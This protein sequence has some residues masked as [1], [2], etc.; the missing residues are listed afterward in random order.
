MFELAEG[1][2]PILSLPY[3]RL[4]HKELFSRALER[5]LRPLGLF[6]NRSLGQGR[7]RGPKPNFYNMVRRRLQASLYVF[8]YLV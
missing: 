6:E 2:Q 3:G 5:K 4:Q 8:S 1:R 7:T